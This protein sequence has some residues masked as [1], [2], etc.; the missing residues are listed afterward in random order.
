M[1]QY[2]FK[3]HRA[4]KEVYWGIST[5]IPSG[6]RVL[7]SPR[8]RETLNSWEPQLDKEEWMNSS[9]GM[10]QK[11][12]AFKRELVLALDLKQVCL[13]SVEAVET[14][15]FSGKTHVQMLY[16]CFIS[17]FIFWFSSFGWRNICCFKKDILEPPG[18]AAGPKRV[19]SVWWRAGAAG[20]SIDM[21]SAGLSCTGEDYVEGKHQSWLEVGWDDLVYRLPQ[22]PVPPALSSST[23]VWELIIPR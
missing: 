2:R 11:K 13:C 15:V 23:P 21:S 19:G 6:R 22:K 8:S 7:I 1:Y 14:T 4:V 12:P 18:S 17:C 3:Y 20:F 5:H 16:L 9:V 10:S